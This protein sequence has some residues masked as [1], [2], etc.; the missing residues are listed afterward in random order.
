MVLSFPY[1]LD[2]V[3]VVRIIHHDEQSSPCFVVFQS[4]SSQPNASSQRSCHRDSRLHIRRPNIQSTPPNTSTPNTKITESSMICPVVACGWSYGGFMTAWL[5]GHYHVWRAAV[6]GAALTEGDTFLFGGSPWNAK[7]RDI[8]RKQSPITYAL[9]VTA[10]T[11]IMGDVGDS[12]VPLLNSYEWFH[13]LRYAGVEVE[14][15]AYPTDGHFPD[16]IVRT[17]DVYRRWVEWMSERLK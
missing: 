6:A 5:T 3:E 11:L 17:T 12:C 14:F 7:Y 15:Y 1:V 16:G 4:C 9:N 13:A 8:W 2:C 10:P